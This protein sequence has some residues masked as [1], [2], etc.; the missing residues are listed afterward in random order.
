MISQSAGGFNCIP[1]VLLITCVLLQ[2][3]YCFEMTLISPEPFNPES[4][5][6]FQ[7][8][9][10][11]K[12]YNDNEFNKKTSCKCGELTILEFPLSED[13][14]DIKIQYDGIELT[15]DVT[16]SGL[17]EKPM[18]TLKSIDSENGIITINANCLGD[19]TDVNTYYNK[20]D[21][22]FKPLNSS[23]IDFSF[24]LGCDKGGR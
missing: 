1:K 9:T 16:I 7:N 13:H 14:Y 21:M 24:L 19:K 6:I 18:P 8:G 5:S 17:F 2:L 11:S 10:R 3:V 23:S 22:S 12:Y 20:I 15:D 4:K